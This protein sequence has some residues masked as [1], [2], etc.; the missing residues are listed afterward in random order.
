MS[1]TKTSQTFTLI[2]RVL[3]GLIFVVFGLNFFLHF[4]HNAPPDPTSRAGQFLGGLFASGYFFQLLKVLEILIGLLLLSGF[5]T[6]LA[7]I[8]IFPI[9]INILLF[10]AILAPAGVALPLIIF[11]LNIYL[12]WIYRE[13]YVP[14]FTQNKIIAENKG[15]S[16]I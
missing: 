3:L 6:P 12:A 7:L 5:Y 13:A 15:T 1:T 14:L 4:I 16:S 10:H 11:A 8:L 2:A 9:S